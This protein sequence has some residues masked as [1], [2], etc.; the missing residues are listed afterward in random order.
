MAEN[1]GKKDIHMVHWLFSEVVWG[2]ISN[3]LKLNALYVQTTD[4]YLCSLK[5]IFIVYLL[6]VIIVM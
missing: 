4:L 2:P 6:D 1:W 5:S 3:I